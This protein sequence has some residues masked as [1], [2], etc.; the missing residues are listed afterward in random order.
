MAKSGT[1]ITTDDLARMGYELCPDGTA[2][3][4]G[5]APAPP[6]PA[7]PPTKPQQPPSSPRK[8]RAPNKTETLYRDTQLR[9][10]DARYEGVTFR[11]ANGHRYTPD[12]VVVTDGGRLE[13]H[14]V[15][16]TYRLQSYQRAR[17]AFDQAMVEWPA[18]T[19]VWAEKIKAG[20]WKITRSDVE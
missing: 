2:R 11:F 18:A 10:K 8:S 6:A 19:W 16:G 7:A 14:E 1:A 12:W 3:R 15:K 5:T 9:G 4:I 20:G 17:L 13:C